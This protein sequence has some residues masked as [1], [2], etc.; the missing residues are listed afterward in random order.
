MAQ[1]LSWW[2]RRTVNIGYQSELERGRWSD[3]RTN[4]IIIDG[5]A[6]TDNDKVLTVAVGS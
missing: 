3:I 5:I 2:S 6:D 1:S 4:K